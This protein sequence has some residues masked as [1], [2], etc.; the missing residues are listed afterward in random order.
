MRVF[1][2]SSLV[3]P[4]PSTS[5]DTKAS[6]SMRFM[7]WAV[8]PRIAYAVFLLTVL[9]RDTCKRFV[10]DPKYK[11]D[12]ESEKARTDAQAEIKTL[13]SQAEQQ[14]KQLRDQVQ[15]KIP[16]VVAKVVDYIRKG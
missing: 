15:K 7:C 3:K 6:R 4:S 14:R 2:S 11:G 5:T 1:S 12:C 10:S 8:G 16:A 13:K 9:S